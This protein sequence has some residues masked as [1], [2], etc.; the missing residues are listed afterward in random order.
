MELLAEMLQMVEICVIILINSIIYMEAIVVINR[1]IWLDEYANIIDVVRKELTS[2]NVVEE[3]TLEY[4]MIRLFSKATLSMC[5]IYILMNNGYPHGALAL[6]RQIYETIVIMDYLIKH[7]EDNG[8]LE[9]FYDDIKISSLNIQNEY[10]KFIKNDT[11][12]SNNNEFEKYKE[13]YKEYVSKNGTFSN[14]WWIGKG[15]VF[16][17]LAKLTDFNKDYMYKETSESV[18]MS[19]YNANVY[20]GDN[21]EGILIG[22]T[23]D[24]IEKAGW[25]SMLCYCMAMDLFS[26]VV[27]IEYDGLILQSKKLISKIRKR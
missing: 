22:E 18:H 13:K 17:S 14:Y 8:L 12:I 15:C 9:R 26:N 23:Y 5:E 10:K 19:F 20:I 6:S 11:E 16:S 1:P 2:I 27:D 3:R 24:G 7:N 25:Y 4:A 21:E